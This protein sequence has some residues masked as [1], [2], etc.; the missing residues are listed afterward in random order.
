M[1]LVQLAYHMSWAFGWRVDFGPEQLMWECRQLNAC[2]TYPRGLPRMAM[3][4]YPNFKRLHPGA[5]SELDLRRRTLYRKWNWIV[6]HYS[7]MK[8][9]MADDKLIALSGLAKDMQNCLNDRYLAGLWERDLAADM[10][11]CI[12]ECKQE[13]SSPSV[14]PTG[15]RAPSWPWASVDGA[16]N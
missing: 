12:Q 7:R 9:T 3:R 10:M 14:R 5:R 6:F 15:Y 16:I 8:L 11:W 1:V 4:V 13:D 2:E